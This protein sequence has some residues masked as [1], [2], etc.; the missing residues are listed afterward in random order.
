MAGT[1]TVAAVSTTRSPTKRAVLI[2]CVA[3]LLSISVWFSASF[4][5]KG[6]SA[7]WQV[8]DS[9]LFWVTF[10]VQA[11]FIVGAIASALLRLPDRLSA[12]VLYSSC[13]AG[14]ATAN[15]LLLMFPT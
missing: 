11:G 9:Q 4:V 2:I 15:L 8:P 6:I 5:I 12:R 13:A 7:Q 14:A 3:T 1:T 10:G